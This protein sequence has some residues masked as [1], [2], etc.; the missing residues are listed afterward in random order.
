MAQITIGGLDLEASYLSPAALEYW[1]AWFAHQ[2]RL[3][4][5][6][7]QEFAAKIQVLPEELQAEATREFTSRLDFDNVPTLVLL[8]TLRS[9]PAVKTLCIL[10]T[11]EDVVTEDNVAAAFT[12]LLPFIT[13]TE[14][15]CGSIEE[16]NRLRARVGKPPFG[17]RPPRGDSEQQ[18][19]SQ[20]APEGG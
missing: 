9:L 14:V 5:N 16:A 1:Q 3:A 2:S 8:N 4:Y 7:F 11:G 6:P 20:Q 15:T 12:Q 13:A 19:A 10:V 17:R 18:P